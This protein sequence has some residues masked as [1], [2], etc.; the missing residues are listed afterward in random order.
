MIRISTDNTCHVENNE[1]IYDK[2]FITVMNYHDGIAAVRDESGAYHIDTKGNEIY[3]KRFLRTFGYYEGLAAVIDGSGAYH[4]DTEGNPVYDARFLWAGNFQEGR[5]PVRCKDGSYGSIDSAGKLH[6]AGVSYIGDYSEGKAVVR[7]SE[8]CYYANAE[9][10]PKNRVYYGD[11]TNFCNRTAYVSDLDGY[12]AIDTDGN[13]IGGPVYERIL[14]FDKD[15]FTAIDKDHYLIDQGRKVMKIGA[16]CDPDDSLPAWVDFVRG[17]DWDSCVVFMRHGNRSAAA[18]SDCHAPLTKSLT[19]VGVR[20]G[21]AIWKAISGSPYKT[22]RAYS[23]PVSRCKLSA[24]LITGG[25]VPIEDSVVLGLPGTA[26]IHNNDQS[27]E[28]N[29]RPL[30]FET[31]KHVLGG[32][33]P[34]WYPVETCAENIREFFQKD[35]SEKGT[36][37]LAVSHDAFLAKLVGVFM[38]EFPADKWFYF[39]DGIVLFTKNDKLFAWYS[40]KVVPVPPKLDSL[41]IRLTGYYNEDIEWVGKDCEGI[42]TFRDSRGKYG[43]MNEQGLPITNERF[44]YAGD[45][46]YSIAVVGVESKGFTY[47]TDVGEYPLRQWF[48]EC[49][50]FHKGYATVKDSRGWCHIDL[51]GNPLYETRFAYAEPFYNEVALCRDFDGNWVLVH[52][53]GGSEVIIPGGKGR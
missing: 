15:R 48:E 16:H 10:L 31:L 5:C 17:G 43:F 41:G 50:P 45:I 22:L 34:G 44:D 6:V 14:R 2:K 1:P 37:A 11:C 40:G 35:L 46:K 8:G 33:C 30:M 32:K 7:A 52:Q 38:K 36:L 19:D 20:R 9:G 18:N 26:F 27:D 4:I 23:S 25:T 3:S 12:H 21:Q 28:T 53:D 49:T 47:I 29:K 24:E 51:S 42:R 39:Y 13:R